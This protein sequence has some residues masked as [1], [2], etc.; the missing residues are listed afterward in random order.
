MLD[1]GFQQL[2]IA[3]EMD[4]PMLRA[5]AYLTIARANERLGNLEKAVSYCR[6]SLYNQ[7]DQSRTTGYVQLTLGNTYVTYSSFSKAIEH[8]E[9]ALKVSRSI[10]DTA[11]ELQ[12]YCGLGHTFCLLQDYER[13]L[14]FSAKAFELSKTFHIL[15][16]NSRYQ[17][18]SLVT[19]ATPLRKLGRLPEARDC[20]QVCFPSKFHPLRLPRPPRL[21]RTLPV[22]TVC[23]VV[24]YGGLGHHF[25]GLGYSLSEVTS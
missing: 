12:V 13:S 19:L 24:I 14:S 22:H 15:D 25:R 23:L 17:R 6:H 7:C 21:Q 3:N 9:L 10:H 8:Y 18:L 11:L 2:D 5:E 1:F 16:L 4:S 20:C